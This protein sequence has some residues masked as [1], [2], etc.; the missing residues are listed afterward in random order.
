M[1]RIFAAM[2][3]FG[4]AIG[5]IFPFVVD[6]FVTWKPEYRIY[7]R[8][9]CLV[10]G[11]AVGAFS[12]QIIKISLFRQ[13]LALEQA[14]DSFTLLTQ[15]AIRERDWSIDPSDPE[16]P[17]CWQVKNCNQPDC[18]VYGK[19]HMRCWLIAGTFC[20]GDIQGRFAQKLATCADC[21]V[22]AGAVKQDPIREIGESF[23]GLMWEVSERE[24]A[25]AEA[26]KQLQEM[27]VTDFLT[28]LKNHGVFQD[29]LEREVARAKRFQQTLSI[30]ML[31]LDHFKNVNDKFGH[32][33]GDAVLKSV[34]R[35]LASEVRIMDFSARY[36]GEEFV[37]I[38]PETAGVAAVDV[39][40]KLRV[41]IK[42]QVAAETGLPTT[43]VGASFGV[44]DYPR[45]ATDK[46]GL[47]AAA[48]SA[49]LFSKR[50]GRNQ[51]SYFL[52]LTN[53]DL[54]Q[55]DIEELSDRLG[56]AGLKTISALAEAV[57]SSDGYSAADSQQIT[58]ASRSVAAAL[59][60][61][62]EQTESL[63]LATKLHDIGKVGIPD[64]ILSKKEALSAAEISRVRQ[65]PAIGQRILHEAT[66]VKDVISA[67][68][69]HHENWD[70]S[71][72]PE[73]L[74]GEDIPV[75]ARAVSIADAF[76]AM[77]SNRPYRNAL[78]PQQAIAQLREGAGKQ[79]DPTL[80]EL[81]IQALERHE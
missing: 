58:D 48:D 30:I 42:E 23:N 16:I 56:G 75:M 28:G 10:A 25:L 74:K 5:L 54:S 20:D 17:T 65:H 32:Q 8:L 9:A 63:I 46:D 81:F 45:C 47:I 27:A 71:G 19:H 13:K 55:S 24:K 62:E 49:L 37:I 14:K 31:D 76:R 50:K 40:E 22:Y 69:Y 66:A 77:T 7:F 1:K 79:F 2:V 33:M 26:N 35:I 6:P 64:S 53:T 43:Y 4:L 12:F 39:A 61:S 18:P 44:G 60:M 78:T 72:Y 57:N 67:I 68:L 29:Q 59:G 80:V 36:G 3:V 51:V 38:L 11:F 34:G 21:N 15:T 41:K 52:D 73:Q 70:G